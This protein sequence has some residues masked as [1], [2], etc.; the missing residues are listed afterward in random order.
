M[1]TIQSSDPSPFAT[2]DVVTTLVIRVAK[3]GNQDEARELALAILQERFQ[4]IIDDFEE[5]QE[6]PRIE[7]VDYV[8][9][10]AND[11]PFRPILAPGTSISYYGESATVILDKGGAEI[12]VRTA[13]D[14]VEKWLWTFEGVTCEVV[15]QAKRLT[16]L[17]DL[18][19]KIADADE[20]M[21]P[22]TVRAKEL[23]GMP[24]NL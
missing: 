5:S 11:K 13:E 18:I 24:T 19:Q 15:D 6:E 10:D 4:K 9:L 1:T 3:A 2:H 20:R 16:D 8:I 23:M 12:M 7:Q 21:S 14:Q 22:W 17:E